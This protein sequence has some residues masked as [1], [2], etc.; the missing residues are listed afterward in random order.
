MKKRVL[1]GIF[2]VWLDFNKDAEAPEMT[3]FWS[4]IAIFIDLSFESFCQIIS[5]GHWDREQFAFFPYKE[6][7]CKYWFQAIWKYLALGKR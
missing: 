6:N 3:G 4:D 5:F 7:N 2:P 1:F